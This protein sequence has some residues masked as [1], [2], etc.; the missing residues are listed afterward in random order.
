MVDSAEFV[1]RRTR[2]T[3]RQIGIVAALMLF[4][5]IFQVTAYV[6]RE[7]FHDTA[8]QF[9]LAQ[10]STG[11]LSD[12]QRDS[13]KVAL[14][15]ERLRTGSATVDELIERV[16]FLRQQ[17]RNISDDELTPEVRPQL[18]RAR[19]LTTQILDWAAR[20]SPG[21]ALTVAADETSL[22]VLVDELVATI[23]EAYTATE[24]SFY[25][26]L[27]VRLDDNNESFDRLLWAA[28]VV[29]GVVIIGA[30]V[31]RRAVRRDFVRAHTLVELEAEE[32]RR[33]QGA[34]TLKDRR[35]AALMQH[36]SDLTVVLDSVGAIRFV[37]P[38]TEGLLP[39]VG[40][41]PGAALQLVHCGDRQ[42]AERMFITC[43]EKLGRQVVEE[44]RLARRANE[45]GHTKQDRYFEV[46]MTNLLTEPAVE[47]IVINGREVTE[48][49]RHNDE[50]TY[51]A[52][53][54]VLT[55]LPNG[56]A[57]VEA[58]NTRLEADEPVTV[59]AIDLDSF[60]DINDGFGHVVG[61]ELLV[62]VGRRLR[63][64]VDDDDV[65]GRPNGDEFVVV[66]SRPADTDAAARLTRVML[67]GFDDPF[68]VGGRR[69]VADA[70]AGISFVSPSGKIHADE[71]LRRADAAM[72]QAKRNGRRRHEMFDDREHETSARRLA[73]LEDL[74]R[75]LRD[76]ELSIAF[77][78]IVPLRTGGRPGAEA[79]LR[80]C[81]RGVA[82]SPGE[83]IPVAEDAGVIVSI[84]EWVL[85][86]S[87]RALRAFGSH[88]PAYLSVNLSARE[89]L[90]P[91]LAARV[92]QVVDDYDVDP[93]SLMF[94][95]TETSLVQDRSGAIAALQS[96]R[97]LGARVAIDDFGTGHSS[98]SY[99]TELPVD[100]VKI[101]RSFIAGVAA[102]ERSSR[103]LAAVVGM[104]H[105][106]GMQVVCE[107]IELREQ[108]QAVRRSGCDDAQGFLLAA[109][110]SRSDLEQFLARYDG[111][112]LGA[113]LGL[114]AQTVA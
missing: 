19:E 56:A 101:D 91:S 12:A 1:L 41:G 68:V 23:V 13:L 2:A 64:L 55:G 103:F 35:M 5:G 44:L 36:S 61:D 66:S 30:A 3:A 100:V 42:L 107:G 106:L 17:L 97:A 16:S 102:D 105:D 67:G 51:R 32:R 21:D 9:G 24:F 80:W 92:R 98:L 86:Q 34:L 31:Y 6:T 46:R 10:N 48:R 99:L 49:R 26:R 22:T 14:L 29:S 8:G 65:V 40:N 58:V 50:L 82:I 87:C 53:H 57:I 15:A 84:G 79:L 111:V 114:D 18:D 43:L 71:L 110:M 54:D 96:L 27:R 104:A 7:R 95:L 20:A 37:G 69:F 90:E 59:V 4:V 11:N 94:E 76:G 70:S 75:A 28:L 60:K 63:Q 109:P 83:F 62:A 85:R 52:Y 25:E 33:A 45:Q 112:A 39:A 74:S 38:S 72:Y 113:G 88:R 47:G 78:P 89:L 81:R 77:Q 73:M 108:L 93:T